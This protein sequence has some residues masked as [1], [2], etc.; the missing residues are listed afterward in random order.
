MAP[1]PAL[2]EVYTVA[3]KETV[4]GNIVY[5]LQNT[6]RTFVVVDLGEK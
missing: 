6:I 1:L 5:H 3:P 2:P 4:L